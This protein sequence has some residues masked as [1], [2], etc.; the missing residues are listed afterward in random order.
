MVMKKKMKIVL[1][2]IAAFLQE[3]EK[4]EKREREC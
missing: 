4:R 1:P 3:H 2:V